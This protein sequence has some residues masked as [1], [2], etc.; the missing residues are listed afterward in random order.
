MKYIDSKFFYIFLYFFIFTFIYSVAAMAEEEFSIVVKKTSEVS[1]EEVF[2]EDIA[3]INAPSFLKNEIGMI[4]I[5]SSPDPGEIK[6]ILK[7]R[8]L[9][10]IYSNHLIDQTATVSVPEKIYVK[11]LTQRLETDYLKECFLKY[12]ETFHEDIRVDLRDFNVRGIEPYPKGKLS[13]LFDR[14]SRLNK[15]G[16]F[17][18]K[19][20]VLIDSYNVDTLSLSGWIDVYER[21]V[22]AR[23]PLKRHQKIE[24]QDLFYQIVNTSKFRKYCAK[25]IE[26]VEG[27]IP[28][29]DINKGDYIKISLLKQAPL[30]RK[31]DAVKLVAKRQGLKIITAGIS[32]EDGVADDLIRVANLRSGKIIRGFV[33]GKSLVEVYY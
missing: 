14:D 26:N 2:L 25:K 11:R 6:I 18:I 10:K 27:K 7:D 23:V 1:S 19:V 5:G 31:G 16:R 30:V 9:A 33:K 29:N 20:D 24:A 13:L 28:K 17:A 12:V 3:E 21:L 32:K 8:L 4:V 15:K 22:C